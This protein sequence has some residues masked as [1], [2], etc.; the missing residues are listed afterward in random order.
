MNWFLEP[1]REVTDEERAEFW[2]EGIAA[3]GA[4]VSADVVV[5]LRFC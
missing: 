2:S 4:V 1:S 5:D 3:E